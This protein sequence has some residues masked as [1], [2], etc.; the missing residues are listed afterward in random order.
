MSVPP[1]NVFVSYSHEDTF[2]MERLLP[3]LYFRGVCVDKFTDK[4]IKPGKRWDKDIKDALARM[5]IF[6][7]LLSVG[8]A[9][10]RY[11]S[12]IEDPIARRR[13]KHGEI[14]VLPI[15]IHDPGKGECRWMRGL[16]WV[17]PG[18]LSWAEIHRNNPDHDIARADIRDGIREVV[19]R[20]Q[21]RKS[22]GP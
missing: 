14:E 10:S 13:H 17:P 8:F 20:V 19:K 4:E 2:W 6:L 3:L 16:Q 22:A 12:K 5:D 1:V 9:A 7:P 18:A 21:S 11:I 15:L